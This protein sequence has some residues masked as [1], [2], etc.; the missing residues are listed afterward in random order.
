M[1]YTGT[2]KVKLDLTEIDGNA[3]WLIGAFRR[4]AKLQGWTADEIEAVTDDCM[5]GNYD[6]LLQVLIGVTA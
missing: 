1:S 6:H 3:F 4:Q 5:S 2:K